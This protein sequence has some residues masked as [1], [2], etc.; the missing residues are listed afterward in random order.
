M[1]HQLTRSTE[2]V[3]SFFGPSSNDSD[4][5]RNTTSGNITGFINKIR[6]FESSNY[7]RDYTTFQSQT[8]QL[9]KNNVLNMIASIKQDRDQTEKAHLG[10]A[11]FIPYQFFGSDSWL[12]TES[13]GVNCAQWVKN[14]L[15]IAGLNLSQTKSKPAKVAGSSCIIF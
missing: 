4:P 5:T 13:N 15:A 8:W 6:C 11:E 10:A 12:G 9:P 14:K 1:K 3:S 2:W 7:Q